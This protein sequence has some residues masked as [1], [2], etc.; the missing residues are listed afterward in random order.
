[1]LSR[2]LRKLIYNANSSL[3]E[4]GQLRNGW[5]EEYQ[6]ALAK[7]ANSYNGAS[8]PKDVFAAIHFVST[9]LCIRYNARKESVAAEIAETESTLGKICLETDIF[10]WTAVTEVP[11]WDRESLLTA[12]E[13]EL[14]SLC[15][16]ALSPVHPVTEETSFVEWKKSYQEC[17]GRLQVKVGRDDQWRKWLCIAFHFAAFYV[18]LYQQQDIALNDNQECVEGKSVV[19]LLMSRLSKCIEN[20]RVLNLIELWLKSASIRRNSVGVPQVGEPRPRIGR[21]ISVRT[22]TE[23][24]IQSSID[25]R[26]AEGQSIF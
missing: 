8:W 23:L 21:F 5:F 17:L 4:T 6:A 22:S 26:E 24:L 19:S 1:M 11:R 13:A 15:F 3:V 7:V 14:I 18:D 16:G 20:Q 10:L 9:H 25:T 12:D 2:E